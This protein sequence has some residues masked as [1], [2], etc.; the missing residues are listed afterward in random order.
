MV[1][2]PQEE[3]SYMDQ[4]EPNPSLPRM[5]TFSTLT[6][7]MYEPLFFDEEE[8][9]KK[10]TQRLVCWRRIYLCTSIPLGMTKKWAAEYNGFY[11]SMFLFKRLLGL[12][13]PA[14]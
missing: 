7:C 11:I 13:D 2:K 8:E 4:T 12:A 14:C 9:E 3:G 5:Y 6:L 1:Y 10:V